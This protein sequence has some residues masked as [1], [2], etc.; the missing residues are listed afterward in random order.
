MLTFTRFNFCT[1]I[2]NQIGLSHYMYEILKTYKNMVLIVNISNCL[3]VS[4]SDTQVYAL[5][6][7]LLKKI[8]VLFMEY[9]RGAI[10]CFCGCTLDRGPTL[11]EHFV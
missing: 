10:I 8:G 6:M 1:Y 2:F 5:V 7:I 9:I 11:L 4:I 3:V